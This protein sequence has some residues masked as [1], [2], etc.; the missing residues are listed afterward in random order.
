MNNKLLIKMLLTSIMAATYV[1]V[2]F[3][4]QPLSFG[5]I[6]F[7][8]SEILC[9][10]AIDYSWALIGVSIGCLLSNAFV[11]GLGMLDIVFG[12][13]AT[14]IGCVLAYIFRKR[15]TKGYPLLSTSMIVLANA[16]IVGIELGIIFETTNLIWLYM[17]EVGFGE[18]VVLMMGL[19]IYK[20]TKTII[21]NKLN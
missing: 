12:T 13:M 16:I 5:P 11:G 10:F 19:P 2:C 6:Q 18:F 8:F 7:R 4:L 14:V 21:D 20:K 3:V 15:I 1:A 17:L 9:L